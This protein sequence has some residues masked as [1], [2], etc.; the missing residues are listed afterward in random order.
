[1]T[2]MNDNNDSSYPK[3]RVKKQSNSVLYLFIITILALT[4]G[5]FF[6]QKSVISDQEE[7][8]SQSII[9]T[10]SQLVD[11]GSGAKST[12]NSQLSS[13]TESPLSPIIENNSS[14]SETTN[15][16]SETRHTDLGMEENTETDS[17]EI[18]ETSL[19]EQ[20]SA[21]ADSN[22]AESA[23]V[24]YDKLVSQLDDF[25]AHLDSQPYMQAFKL[26][27]PSREHF[28]K[29]MQKLLENP[30]VVTRETD[31][32][33]TLLKNTAHFFRILGKDNILVL[34]G[35]LDREKESFESILQ[36]LYLLTGEPQVMREA[37]SLDLHPEAL[38][39]YAGF[40]LNTMGGRLYLFRRDSNSRMAVNFYAIM[41]VDRANDS[42][43]SRHGIDIRPA[44]DSLIDEIE[45]GGN[46]LKMREQYLDTLYD[47]KVKYS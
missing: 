43:N 7:M 32:L 1:M 47:L 35:I 9:Q 6:Y 14:P 21:E 22:Q 31:D 38:Y 17:Q 8:Q 39:D 25:Y 44:I 18:G 36:S 41:V 28:S 40:F 29:L 42:G 26:P 37:Y 34:K 23:V 5:F 30:P 46:K 2:K 20:S 12:E 4:G 27:E 16:I 3:S 19:G 33:F 13:D 15:P 11:Q 10:T 45:N 24:D